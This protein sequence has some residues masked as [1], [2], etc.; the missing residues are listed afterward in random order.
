MR[1]TYT[2]SR[3]EGRAHNAIDIIAPRNASVLA[4][5]DGKI[6]KLLTNER[7][8]ITIYQL[9]TDEK[10]VLY[11]AHLERYADGLTEGRVAKQG[12]VIGYVGDTGNA[13]A[14][15]THLHF[16]IWSITDPKRYWSGLNLN[17]YPLLRA[18]Q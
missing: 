18:P 17:P 8:G 1:D 11:Y 9:S 16:A 6:I 7:G 5:A 13:V 2:E 10:L 14:G 4:A 3:S 12:E 15:N